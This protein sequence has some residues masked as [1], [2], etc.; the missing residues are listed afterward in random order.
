MGIFPDHF[1]DLHFIVDNKKFI[2][3]MIPLRALEKAHFSYISDFIISLF[4]CKRGLGN[5]I[6]MIV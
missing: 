2:H 1:T 5:D 4:N 6:V 3:L